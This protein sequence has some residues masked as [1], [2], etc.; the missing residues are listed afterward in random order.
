MIKQTESQT[1]VLAPSFPVQQSAWEG[2]RGASISASQER[3]SS[4]RPND[5]RARLVKPFTTRAVNQRLSWE[6][7]RN[8]RF[9]TPQWRCQLTIYHLQK[10]TNEGKR[11]AWNSSKYRVKS[12]N[13]GSKYLHMHDCSLSAVWQAS[14]II[15]R[16]KK[17]KSL[18]RLKIWNSLFC[19]HCVDLKPVC[20]GLLFKE[21]RA[22]NKS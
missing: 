2:K 1:D 8:R 12:G 11:N 16:L 22:L 10:R 5:G 6:E 21:T 4:A 18:I 15:L 19:Q 14:F 9:S 17:V 13:M 3:V 20:A 7:L